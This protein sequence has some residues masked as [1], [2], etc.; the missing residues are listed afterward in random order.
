[1]FRC[2]LEEAFEAFAVA[3]VVVDVGQPDYVLR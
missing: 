1:M 2:L 3:E